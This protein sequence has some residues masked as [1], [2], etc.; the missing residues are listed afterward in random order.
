MANCFYSERKCL[1]KFREKLRGRCASASAS[2]STIFNL[3][4]EVRESSM[5][6]EKPNLRRKRWTEK[7]TK[8]LKNILKLAVNPQ[9][10]EDWKAVAKTGQEC[11]Q[12]AKKIQWAPP[13][14]S[15]SSKLSVCRDSD[16]SFEDDASSRKDRKMKPR[17][18]SS[19]R[20]SVNEA[21]FFAVQDRHRY[22][23]SLELDP[24][25]SLLQ[26]LCSPDFGS[27]S[28]NPRKPFLMKIAVDSPLNL[29][30]TSRH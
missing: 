8:R 1:T 2:D 23:S 29:S 11:K 5:C 3:K 24:D 10:D 25:D 16:E 21:D 20:R 13:I 30:A 4:Q 9:S 6:D 7:E 26:V 19:F 18:E 14:N 28:R 22:S 12:Q 27:V 15:M 17:R